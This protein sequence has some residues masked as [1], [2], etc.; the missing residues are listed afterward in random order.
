MH[1]RVREDNRRE[2]EGRMT[3][4]TV[5]TERRRLALFWVVL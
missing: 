4:R 1:L 5:V 2:K 3:G